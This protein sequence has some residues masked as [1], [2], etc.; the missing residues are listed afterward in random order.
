MNSS[1]LWIRCLCI[2]FKT[3]S[4]SQKSQSP[5]EDK[6][7]SISEEPYVWS[8]SS[9][10]ISLSHRIPLV[11][12]ISFSPTPKSEMGN[13]R[14]QIRKFF[15]GRGRWNAKRKKWIWSSAFLSLTSGQWKKYFC[16]SRPFFGSKNSVGPRKN[17]PIFFDQL[18]ATFS[19]FEV[20]TSKLS[21]NR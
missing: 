18:R 17:S 9:W 8:R 19:E 21:E 10:W 4:S 14:S 15:G 12:E 6:A 11:L 1:N 20:R 2:L 13:Y 5:S 3:G 7:F 16:K